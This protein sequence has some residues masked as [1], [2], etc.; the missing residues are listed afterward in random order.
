MLLARY[1]WLVA[2]SPA[3]LPSKSGSRVLNIHDKEGLAPRPLIVT[4]SVLSPA[5]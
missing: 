1:C 3:N 5:S 4:H 2:H